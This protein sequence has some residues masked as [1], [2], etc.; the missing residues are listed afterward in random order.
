M[1]A[2]LFML[3]QV[4]H[5]TWVSTEDGLVPL[6][7]FD[8]STH[9]PREKDTEDEQGYCGRLSAPGYMDCTDWLG[10]F[11]TPR[12]AREAILETHEV[13]PLTG[14]PVW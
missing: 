2:R 9:G 7:Y 12:E 5:G 6:E 1:K 13:C 4:E 14:R 10:P 8:P 3:P 11:E